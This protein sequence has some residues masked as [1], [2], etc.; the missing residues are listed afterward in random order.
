M[1][2]LLDAHTLLMT[3]GD[4]TAIVRL[5]GAGAVALPGATG[6]WRDRVL[7]TEDADV[8]NEATPIRI[9]TA[10]PV[11]AHFARA[12]AIVFRGLTFAS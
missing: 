3:V 6:V 2:Y 1:R 9:D 5:S 11:T 7:T 10:A 4:L 12:G 8:T